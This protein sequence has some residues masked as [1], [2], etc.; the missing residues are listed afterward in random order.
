MTDRL[1][2][3][4]VDEGELG[5]STY[6]PQVPGFTY[7]RPTRREWA[8]DLNSALEFARAPT[9]PRVIHEER[10]FATADNHEFLI[11]VANDEHRGERREYADRLLRVLSDEPQGRSVLDAPALA[12]GEILI[13]IVLPTDKLRS[14]FEQ[15]DEKDTVLVAAPVG[16][17]GIMTGVLSNDDDL[18]GAQ[19]LDSM[20]LNEDSSFSDWMMS[21]RITSEY[22]TSTALRR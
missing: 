21:Q 17:T 22:G 4:V 12:T 14:V 8:I 9:L 5:L 19:P 6:S 16:E 15:I 7:G 11:R 18:P 1:H 10:R 20:G 3:V 13:I 2:V